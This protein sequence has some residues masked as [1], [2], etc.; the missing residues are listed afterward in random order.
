M[1]KAFFSLAILLAWSSLA[2]AAPPEFSAYDV[3]AKRAPVFVGG[4]AAKAPLAFPRLDANLNR[5]LAEGGE[6][7]RAHALGLKAQ[8]DRVQVHVIVEEGEKDRLKDWLAQEGA[9]GLLEAGNVL[10][11]FVSRQTL[12]K[13]AAREEVLAVRT[14][15][16]YRPAP[17]E[18]SLGGRALA[19]SLT[20]EALGAMNVP[21]WHAAGIQGQGVK[22]GVIDGGFAGYQSLLGS[23]LPPASKVFVWPGGIAHMGDSE[24]GTMCAEIV[25]D[26]VPQMDGLY[27]AAVAT[28]VDIVNAIQ[29]MQSQGVK[30]I[31]MSMG[32][33]S[34]GPGDGTGTL[35]SAINNFVAAGGFWAN[36][37]GNSRLA[38]WQGSWQDTNGDGWLEFDGSGRVVN[39][40]T[41][42]GTN[43]A[44][45]PAGTYIFASL[46]WNQWSSPATDLD[47]YIAKWNPSL[48]QWE[49]FGKSEDQQNGQAGQRPVEENF[50]VRQADEDTCYGFAIKRWSGPSNVQ[51]EFFNRF[52]GNPLRVYVPDGSLTPPADAS[53]A[54]ATA[55]LHV[56][57]FALEPYSSRGPTN[58]P[59]GSLTG[60]TTKPDLAGYAQVSCNAY[61]PNQC[62]GT[63][64]ASP[65]VGGAAALVASGY[66]TYS[67]AQIRSYLESNAA[68]MGPS[69]KDND[70]GWGRLRLGTPPATSCTA[71]GTPTGL[72]ASK[73]SV[74]S[75]ETFVLSWN[76]ASLADSYEL[77]FATNPGFSGAQSYSVGG[78]ST[79]FSVNTTSSVTAYFRVRAVRSCGASS[80]WSNT[81]QVAVTA[82]GGGG[83]TYEYW[84]PVV[85]NAGG[86]GGSYFYSDVAVLNVGTS[87]ATVNFTYY[88]TGGPFTANSAAP[89]PPNGQGLFRDIVGQMNKVGTKGVLRVS[90]P[91]P[92]RVTSRTYN[93]LGPGNTLGL[94]AGTTFGQYI[95]AY[96]LS[97]TLSAGQV[98]YLVG[99]TQNSAYRT[100][101]AVAN[102]G[103]SP[104]NVTVTL[105]SGTGQT[106]ASYSVTL[107]PGELKQENEVFASKA[108]Q[109]NLESGW[110]KV[111]VNSGSGVVAY[112][113]V[114]DNT[115][116]TTPS[117][118]Q[119]PSDPTTIPFKR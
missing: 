67:G 6:T 65:H 112:A 106:L 113:S 94:A 57:T 62:L 114:L 87:S 118:S 40:I 76:A 15:S 105:Y 99:L 1:W 98:A 103:S 73:S 88:T 102:F 12:T 21:A 61:G 16:Y 68:D 115:A 59:G 53:G 107:N 92:L 39:F 110:A 13:L 78:T 85:A 14:P 27:L 8:A 95:E 117:G 24:H 47:F 80:N 104:A 29:W 97:E 3:A 108:G 119:K 79:N 28:E 83:G 5:W 10:Q 77:Q 35:A 96:P 31:T 36:A 75:G 7:R 32:W 49:I 69:G 45:I 70:Y 25:T 37:A 55:A 66:P 42:D 54:V 20:T 2:G 51:L 101:I 82:G 91:Q 41:A 46:V 26:I 34:W 22:V 86:S 38:H 11:V 17:W 50:D 116:T 48:S 93:K 100:N 58:G 19:G 64:A 74:A 111:V 4:A 60:G 63:S 84:I 72:Q 23:D 90:A 52:D 109:S 9:E 71:P 89:L 81:V 18:S 56:N 30:V 33:P 43:C 44:V